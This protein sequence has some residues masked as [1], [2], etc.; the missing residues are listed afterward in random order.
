MDSKYNSGIKKKME[1][2]RAKKEE[3]Q[4]NKQSDIEFV[5]DFESGNLDLAFRV[6]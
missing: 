6:A 4:M 5:G 3:R 2:F 1:R